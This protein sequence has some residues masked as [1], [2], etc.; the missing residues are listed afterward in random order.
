MTTEMTIPPETLDLARRLLAYEAVAGKRSEPA[1]S[2]AILVYEKLRYSLCAL[3]GVTCFRLLAARALALARTKAPNLSAVQITADGSLQGLG[4]PG[5]RMN[6]SQDGQ[7][8]VILIAQLLGLLRTF[9]GTALTLQLVR[10]VWP[11][12]G[13]TIAI[14]ETGGRE[15]EHAK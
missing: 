8:E 4:E 7:G 2:A 11:D 12:A 13:S 5:P 14:S 3:A 15:D 10:D 6:E 9:I 1:E